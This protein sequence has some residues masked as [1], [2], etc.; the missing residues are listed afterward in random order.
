MEQ[1]NSVDTAW[2]NLGLDCGNSVENDY[3]QKGTCIAGQT[4]L[5]ITHTR[6]SSGTLLFIDVKDLSTNP[7][8]STSNSILSKQI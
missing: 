5:A 3:D 8:P 4:N 7:H 1:P 2:E 6:H